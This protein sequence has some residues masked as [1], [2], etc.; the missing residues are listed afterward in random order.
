MIICHTHRFIFIKTR[1]T[2]SSSVEIGLSRACAGDDV[3]TPLSVQSG[4]EALRAQ[5]GGF[6][7]ANWL[8]DIGEHRSL[9][10][11]R[12]LLFRGQ[13]AQRFAPHTTL[14]ELQTLVPADTLDSYLKFTLERNPWDRAVSRYFWQKHRWERNGHTGFPTLS[15][16]LRFLERDKPH[17]LS[18]WGHYTIDGRIAVDRVLRY[19]NLSSELA[20]LQADLA[21]GASIALPARRAKGGYRSDRLHYSELLSDHDRRLVRRVC[22]P[23]IEAFGYRFEPATPAHP[24]GCQSQ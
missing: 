16:Y 8:K 10:E 21:I 6:G 1:K 15:E 7:P 18:N 17:W 24:S 19:E 9:R 14:A 20:T 3:V 2:A 11:W 5:E 23:E 22:A 13:R 12:R 4:D